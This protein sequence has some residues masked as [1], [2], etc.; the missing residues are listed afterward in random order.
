MPKP[1]N[2]HKIEALIVDDE[3]LARKNIRHSLKNYPNIEVIQ[4]CRN[5]IEAIQAI[6]EHKPDLVFLDIQMPL[7]DG[8]EVIHS[9]DIET[10]PYVI[11]VTAYD[12]YAIQAFEINAIDYLLKPY[13]PERFNESVERVLHAIQNQNQ[14]ANQHHEEIDKLL[15]NL[16]SQKPYINRIA[17]QSSARIYFLNIDEIDWIESSG[18]YITIYANNKTHLIRETMKKI[19]A[20]L[21]P[22]KFI[23]IHRSFIVNL[24]RIVEIQPDGYDFIVILQDGKTLGM[25]RTYK[26]KL[27]ELID[28]Y[29]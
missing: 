17:V 20:K 28:R 27:Q 6:L 14:R 2:D 24:D 1:M 19:E 18:N 23:R 11:F 25:S 16:R 9:L 10:M 26:A 13:T 3:D 8:F 12:S 21:D 29:F 22:E 4:E 7:M 15:T 5:G